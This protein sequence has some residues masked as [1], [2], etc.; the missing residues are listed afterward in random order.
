MRK[1]KIAFFAATILLACWACKKSSDTP[2][3]V[4]TVSALDSIKVRAYIRNTIDSASLTNAGYNVDSIINS[5]IDSII[6]LHTDS[7]FVSVQP[8]TPNNIYKNTLY[9]SYTGGGDFSVIYTGDSTH[10]YNPQSYNP[11]TDSVTSI[12]YSFSNSIVAHTYTST[13]TY[14]ATVVATNV[15]NKGNDINRATLSQTYII[16]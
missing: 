16:K 5:G 13:G 15:K 9:F 12:P 8:N 4:F 3:V 2:T 14:T 1:I 6:V 11:L 7:F 10:I